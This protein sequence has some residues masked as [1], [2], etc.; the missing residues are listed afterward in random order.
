[1][2][3]PFEFVFGQTRD[4]MITDRSLK[5]EAHCFKKGSK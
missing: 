4:A 3:S 1:M 2:K 5:L